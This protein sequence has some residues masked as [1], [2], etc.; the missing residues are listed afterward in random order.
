MF[1]VIRIR[2]HVAVR[3]E[4]EDTMRM[5]GLKRAH[6]LVL[7]PETATTRAMIRKVAGFVTWGEVDDSVAAAWGKTKRLKPPVRGLK[8]IRLPY[9]KGDVG[10]RG[11]DIVKLIERMS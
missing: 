11:K 6:T 5:L 2:G 1:A 8:S 7:L 3:G 4:H 10:Y 9:P